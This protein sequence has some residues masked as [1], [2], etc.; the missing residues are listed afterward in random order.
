MSAETAGD[1]AEKRAQEVAAHLGI[2]D[3]VYGQ[4]LV[5]K[6]KGWREVG[7]GLLVIGDRGAI[8]QV[9][10]REPAPGLRDS[11]DKAERVVRKYIE[12]AIK[13]GY[14]SK[15]TIQLHL[16]SGKPLSATPVRAL[17]FP[18]VHSSIFA[19]KLSRSCEQWPIIVI[20]DHPRNPIFSLSVPPGVF[21]ISLLDWE[22]LHEHTRSVSGILRYIDLVFKSRLPTVIGREE[23]RFSKLAG[24]VRQPNIPNQWESHPWFS[25]AARDDPLGVSVYR[26]LLTKVWT[27]LPRGPGIS[28]EDIRT[29]LAFL[30]DVPTSVM[31]VI[32]RWILRKRREFRETGN[33]A[34][35][36]MTTGNKILVYLH[37]SEQQCSDQAQWTSE[38]TFLTLT[39]LHEWT[40]TY[41]AKAVALGVGTRETENGIEY[42]HVYLEGAG[43]L[44]KEIRDMIEWKYGVH[45]YRLGHV[46]HLKYGRNETCPCGSGMKY[47]RCHGSR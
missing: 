28:P 29:M 30:D 22:Q 11:K 31:V 37:G 40:E 42:T 47:K 3:F 26:E 46:H 24:F 45:N 1:K 34:S 23:E 38:L 19:L 8:L 44:T 18:S 27:G 21:C 6:G 4:P 17:D 10:S 33:L 35:G 16:A 14:G 5:R 15:R 43:G 39:R 7:D 36:G 2:A 13:Q 20:V 32:G 9:K 41:S 25:T 12:A